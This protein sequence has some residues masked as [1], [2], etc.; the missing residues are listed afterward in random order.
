MANG[1]QKLSVTK[2]LSERMYGDDRLL[3]K[4]LHLPTHLLPLATRTKI[5]EQRRGI[6]IVLAKNGRIEVY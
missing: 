1:R 6:T 4:K 5:I 3:K 2:R